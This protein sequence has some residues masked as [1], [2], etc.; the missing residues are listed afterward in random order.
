[1][2]EFDHNIY[3]L[4]ISPALKLNPGSGYLDT[5]SYLVPNTLFSSTFALSH[6][7]TVRE[8]VMSQLR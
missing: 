5:I 1:M 6:E 2:N 4:K 3:I 8:T 7:V